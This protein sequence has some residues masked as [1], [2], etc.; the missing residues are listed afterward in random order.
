MCIISNKVNKVAKT[1][2]LIAVNPSN[3][4]QFVVYSNVV[5]N[6]SSNNAMILPVPNPTSIKFHDLSSYKDIFNDCDKSFYKEEK[7][8]S[9]ST[10]SISY[11]LK[12]C[13]SK[14]EV[15]NVGSYKA[16]IANSLDD[17]KNLDRDV[18]SLTDGCEELLAKEY[19]NP[20]F[21]FII[22]KLDDGNKEYHPFGY[23]HDLP[24]NKKVFIPTKHY[25]PHDLS[26]GINNYNNEFGGYNS[27]YSMF[28]ELNKP[29]KN[30]ESK[31]EWDH[32][33]YLFNVNSNKNYL[34]ES[35]AGLNDIKYCWKKDEFYIKPELTNFNFGKIYHAEKHRAFGDLNN[36]DLILNSYNLFVP[37]PKI[38]QINKKNNND[39]NN[40]CIIS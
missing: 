2:L 6:I 31:D 17:I 3:N 10:N 20:I 22:C 33:I 27:G 8:D 29:H 12:S 25:H 26:N 11:G 13:R 9:F 32:D 1:K 21:G 23:S 37:K 30:I 14:L 38:E 36:T 34:L 19:S 35:S 4:R 16:S 40:S 7:K 39:I 28:Y 18:F 15:Y 24:D 5:N